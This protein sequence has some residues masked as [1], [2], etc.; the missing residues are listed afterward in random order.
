MQNTNTLQTSNRVLV[1]GGG[2]GG[3]RTAL[4]LAEAEK[5]VILVDKAENIGGLMT[6]LDRTFPTNN[7]DLCTLAPNLSESGRQEHISLLSM[8]TVQGVT[9]E[10]GNFTVSLKSAPRYINLDKCTGCGACYEAFPECVRFSPGLDHRAPT[11]MRYPQAIP[12]AYSIELDKCQDIEALVKS[13]PAGAINP[14]DLGSSGEI[15]CGAIVM[16]PGASLFDPSGIDYLGY[17]EHPDVVTSLE[18]ERILSASGPTSGQLLRPSNGEKPKKIAWIQCI[19]SRGLQKGAAP[20]CSGAC[21]MFALKEAMVTKERFQEDIETTIFYMDMRTFGKDYELYYQRAKDDFGIRFIH[22]RPH[23]VLRQ[24]GAEKLEMS[25][26][27]D[28]SSKL[29]TEEYDMVVLST[30]FRVGDDVRDLALKLDIELNESNFPVHSGLNQIATS[31]PGIYVAGTFQGPKDIPETMVQASAAA[32]LAGKDIASPKKSPDDQPLLP[33]E[34]HV[35]GEEPKVGVFICDCGENIGGVIDVEALVERVGKLPHVV[36]AQAEGHGC[37]RESM[38]HIRST[39][40]EMGINRVVI[41]GCSPRTHEAKFQDLIRQEGLNKYLLEM[42]NIRDQVT[43]VHALQPE[44]AVKKAEELIRMAV[45]AVIKAQPLV[46][47]SLPINKNVLVVGGGVTGMTSALELAEQGFKVYLAEKSPDLGGIARDLRKTLEGDDIQAFLGSLIEKTMANENIEVITG[48][49]IVDHSGMPGMFTTG[50]QVGRQM[51]YRQIEHGVTILATGAMPN[52]PSEFM[53]DECKEV[54]TQI[55]IQT[56]IE[57][58]PETVRQWENI[59]MIQCVGSRTKENPNCSRICCQNAIK[60]SLRILEINPDARIFVLYR[61]MRTYG[62]QEE[63]YQKAREKGVIFVRYHQDNPPQAISVDDKVEV[64]FT[65][66]ILGKEIVVTAD[67]LC[68]ST[69]L[70]A[71]QDSTEE[72]AMTFKLPRTHDGFFLEDHV[73]LRPVD[74]PVPGFFVAGTAH[75]PKTIS[76]SLVQARAVASRAQTLL[77][78]EHINLGATTAKVDSTRCASC[79]I[80]VRACPFD[81]PFINADGYSEIDP[82]KCHGCGICATECPAKAIQLMQFEDDQIL[83]KLEQLFEEVVG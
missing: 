70:V 77:A 15:S 47:H 11:C 16:S 78:K 52:R 63:Y 72:L 1:V 13:C 38:D 39:I 37:S 53:L 4:D 21:C 65:D 30:G 59:V 79:L 68:L 26:T 10:K 7:C 36:V 14:D 80:C 27:T 83:S 76:E 22:S 66:I 40:K 2:L 55:E 17:S 71:D 6:Q 48:A 35:V 61:D 54:V 81:V 5:D 32:C 74:L 64:T 18:Y 51:F 49:I 3:I 62:F 20:Y 34:K 44:K 19:G 23:S 60:N 12:Q 29:I 24:P 25:Y 28:E 8:T 42:A 46:E 75:S 82:A 31:R 56:L 43:W 45:G 33:P 73:K 57:D 41:G 67:C 69:G 50:M 9:G 58:Q